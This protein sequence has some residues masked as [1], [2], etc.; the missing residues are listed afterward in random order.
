MQF[1]NKLILLLQ[2]FW[3]TRVANTEVAECPLVD[4]YWTETWKW[5]AFLPFLCFLYFHLSDFLN[6]D[7]F[8]IS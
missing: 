6:A 4:N 3:I 5:S 1:K 2:E 8:A 7:I